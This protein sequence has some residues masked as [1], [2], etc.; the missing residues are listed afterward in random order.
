[1]PED[2]NNQN[3]HFQI[4]KNRIGGTCGTI[5]KDEMYIQGLVVK[6]E[7]NRPFARP[8]HTLED[9]IKMDL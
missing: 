7:E 2:N 5:G 1:M 4:K 8:R 6:H 3:Q 9:N